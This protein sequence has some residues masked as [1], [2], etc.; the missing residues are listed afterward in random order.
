MGLSQR[1][2]GN[3][4]RQNVMNIGKSTATPRCRRIPHRIKKRIFA[5]PLEFEGENGLC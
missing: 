2:K 1:Q 3:G 4:S 5:G